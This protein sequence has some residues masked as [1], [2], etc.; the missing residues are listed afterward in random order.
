MNKFRYCREINKMSQKYVAL[1]V[2]V[3]GPMV[4]QWE[5]GI[6]FPSSENIVKLANLFGVTTDYLLDR[7]TAGGTISLSAEESQLILA[8]RQLNRAG[9]DLLRAAAESY[10]SQATLREEKSISSSIG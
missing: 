8:F 4:S 5:S 6:K 3:S 1:S 9:K 7:E 10:L 2:G